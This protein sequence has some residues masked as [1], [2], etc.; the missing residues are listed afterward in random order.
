MGGPP[1]NGWAD[2]RGQAESPHLKNS[3][4][5]P[6]AL[7]ADLSRAVAD[8]VRWLLSSNAVADTSRLPVAPTRAIGSAGRA[9]PVGHARGCAMMGYG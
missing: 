3:Q 1:P 7:L 6:L 8:R 4:T 2:F 9:G 5:Q